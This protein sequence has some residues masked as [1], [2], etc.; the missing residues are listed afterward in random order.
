MI[1]RAP[2]GKDVGLDTPNNV[3]PAILSTTTFVLLSWASIDAFGS[4]EIVGLGE[5]TST[6]VLGL[7]LLGGS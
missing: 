6:E 3:W 1:T 7:S 5:A 4:T 2:T